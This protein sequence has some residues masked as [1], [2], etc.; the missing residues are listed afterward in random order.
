MFFKPFDSLILIKIIQRAHG[1]PVIKA[2]VKTTDNRESGKEY[3]LTAGGNTNC[4]EHHGD[5]SR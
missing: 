3:L 2:T 5:S 1:A 4:G